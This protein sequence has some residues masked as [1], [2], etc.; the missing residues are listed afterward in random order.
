MRTTLDIDDPVLRELKRRQRA[1]G[2]SL[3]KLASELLARALA[4]PH[5]EAAGAPF[6]WISRDMGARVDLADKEALY[7]AMDAST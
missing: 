4:E 6:A 2:K 3:G 1:E 7:A 5:S